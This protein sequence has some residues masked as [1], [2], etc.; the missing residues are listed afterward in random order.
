MLLSCVTVFAGCASLHSVSMTS[1]PKDRSRPV[2]AKVEKLVFLAFNFNND[3][4][5]SLTPQL[6]GQCQGG[7]VTGITTKYETKFY[8]LAHKMIVTSQGF[9]T[10]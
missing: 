6:Q 8:V 9:C 10:K 1:Y 2:Q 4:I 7:K 3:F 5:Y